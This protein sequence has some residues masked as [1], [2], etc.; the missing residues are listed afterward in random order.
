MSGSPN[1]TGQ[2]YAL[3]YWLTD[4]PLGEPKY[5]FWDDLTAMR[6]HAERVMRGGRF[7]FVILYERGAGPDGWAEIDRLPDD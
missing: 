4:K 3:D 1:D 5:D 2:R 7:R 6:Q